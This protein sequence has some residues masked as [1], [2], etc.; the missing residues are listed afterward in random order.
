MLWFHHF[1]V[2]IGLCYLLPGCFTNSPRRMLP[3][4]VRSGLVV[5]VLALLAL[6]AAEL[7]FLKKLT[8]L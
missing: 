3:W 8:F 1:S 5:Y 2:A 7:R 6:L 4:H